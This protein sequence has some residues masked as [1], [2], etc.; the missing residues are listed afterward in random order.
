[1]GSSESS[2]NKSCNLGRH[3]KRAAIHHV[4]TF[5]HTHDR[6]ITLPL[7]QESAPDVAGAACQLKEDAG[8]H[9]AGK[10][11]FTGAVIAVSVR[12]AV[13][14]I[15]SQVKSAGIQAGK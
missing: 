6:G 14:L 2:E 3:R 4:F 15:I 5:A 10:L 1:L 11:E 9:R 8:L 12:N 7:V 13:I